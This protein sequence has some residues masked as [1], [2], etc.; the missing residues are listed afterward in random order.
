MACGPGS[1]L[2]FVLR[3]TGSPGRVSRRVASSDLEFGSVALR[4]H[5]EKRLREQGADR[6]PRTEMR[7]FV[8]V[9]L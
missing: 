3:A 4:L 5:L 9:P 6:P 7:M 8:S 2:G 1:S